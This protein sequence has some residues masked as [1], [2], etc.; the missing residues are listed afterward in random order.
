M[1]IF[2]IF[3]NILPAVPELSGVHSYKQL[4]DAFGQAPQ[5]I[6]KGGVLRFDECDV[7]V[8]CGKFKAA[9]S[10][11]EQIG[12]D[13]LCRALDAVD[14]YPVKPEV[15]GFKGGAELTELVRLY[16][17]LKRIVPEFL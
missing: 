6:R 9:G 12:S 17:S 10:L 15:P 3:R 14:G 5:I 11:R 8:S 16:K 4:S 7:A 13:A 2:Y 1:L